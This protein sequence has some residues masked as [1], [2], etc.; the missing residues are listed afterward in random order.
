MVTRHRG[1]EPRFAAHEASGSRVRETFLTLSIEIVHDESFL[2]PLSGD[3][4]KPGHPDWKP[5]LGIFK[6]W[7]IGPG[8]S[9]IDSGI[10]HGLQQFLIVGKKI[11]KIQFAMGNFSSYSRHRFGIGPS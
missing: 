10:N 11:V 3:L 4:G 5:S 8:P 6:S 1:D 7:Q 9:Q 2:A